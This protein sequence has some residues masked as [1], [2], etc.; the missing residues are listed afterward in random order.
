MFQRRFVGSR[1]RIG[2]VQCPLLNFSS[3]D[4]TNPAFAN[5]PG[6]VEYRQFVAK[7][8]PN[9]DPNDS[10]GIWGYSAVQTAVQVLTQCGDDFSS[11]NILRQATNLRVRPETSGRIAEF[12][13]HEAD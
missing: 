8:A 2:D 1:S 5:D 3:K 7:Y 11:E 4:P 6:V 10:N 9:V 13:E 12:S